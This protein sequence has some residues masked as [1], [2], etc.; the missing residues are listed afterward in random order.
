[1]WKDKWIPLVEEGQGALCGSVS[2]LSSKPPNST[3]SMGTGGETEALTQRGSEVDVLGKS[4]TCL[5]TEYPP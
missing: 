1:M 5:V 2:L 3:S 4:V